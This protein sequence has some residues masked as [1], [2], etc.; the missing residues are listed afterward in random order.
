[1]HSS[2]EIKEDLKKRIKDQLSGTETVS[3]F[4]FKATEERVT[5]LESRNERARLQTAAKNHAMI[6]PIIL[7]ILK[8][9]GIM[10]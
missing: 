8:D 9:Y 5:R 3:Q 1:M 7:K 4:I 6:E 2:I 10:E